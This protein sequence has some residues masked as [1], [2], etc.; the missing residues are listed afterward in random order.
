MADQLPGVTLQQISV[1]PN[2]TLAE[3]EL[4]PV[5]VAP[6]YRVTTKKMARANGPLASGGVTQSYT[7]VVASY[8]YL[9]PGAVVDLNSVLVTIVDGVV[10]VL[11]SAAGVT[12]TGTNGNIFND[13]TQDFLAAGIAAGDT[14]NVVMGTSV[15]KYVIDGVQLHA[16]TLDYPALTAGTALSYY[17]TRNITSWLLSSDQYVPTAT[18]VTLTTVYNNGDFQFISGEIQLSYRALRADLTGLKTFTSLS[19]VQAVMETNDRQNKLGF[20]IQYGVIPANGNSTAFQVY[21]LGANTSSAYLNALADLVGHTESYML[22]PLCDDLEDSQTVK[23]A[24]KSNVDVM[25]E[26]DDSTFRLLVQDTALI[27][28]TTEIA[29]SGHVGGGT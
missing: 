25:S 6:V 23:N 28:Q 11:A 13:A 26:P 15:A 14:L 24:Y 10:Q 29:S 2:N 22:V 19:D 27:T 9:D 12:T 17:I 8:P 4:Y 1:A 16:L 7:P 5:L 18:D 3:A 20:F 21:C